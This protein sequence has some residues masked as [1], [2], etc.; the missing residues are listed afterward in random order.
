MQW[1]QIKTLF[2]LCFLVL[3]VYLLMQ[4]LD[5]QKENDLAVMEKQESSI[6]QQLKLEDIKIPDLPEGELEESYISVKQKNFTDT[7]LSKLAASDN[8]KIALVEDKTIVSKFDKPIPVKDSDEVKEIVKNNVLSPDSYDYWGWNK[9]LNVIMFFQEKNN[10]PIYYNQKGLLLVFLNDKNE[11]T[12]YTQTMLGE[13]NKDFDNSKKPL[14]KP[15]RAIDALYNQYELHTGEEITDAKIGYYSAQ[16]MA[17]DELIFAPTWKITV[18][19]ERNYFIHAIEGFAFSNDDSTFLEDTMTSIKNSLAKIKDDK[20][21]QEII[22]QLDLKLE[23][24]NRS[25]VE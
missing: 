20:D 7:D 25:E 3:D 8:Q 5:K 4:F 1:S 10:Q 19:G 18:N 13:E 11:I 21:F 17:S 2:I 9:D 12:F 14:I 22:D 24:I 16:P 23:T 6:E 15:I